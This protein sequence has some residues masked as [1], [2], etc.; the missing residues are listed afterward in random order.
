MCGGGQRGEE[1]AGGLSRL[2]GR[3]GHR[4]RDESLLE[5]A[6]THSSASHEAGGS[7]P[8]NEA[9]EL[10]GDAVLGL[11]VAHALLSLAPD[12]DEGALSRWRASLVRRRSLAALGRRLEVGRHLRL[13]QGEEQG[14]GRERDS[15]LADATEALVAALYLDGG[16]EVAR[17]FVQRE[18]GAELMALAGGGAE[19]GRDPKS[20]L[21]ERL[22]AGGGPPPE[23]R[24]LAADG[25]AHAPRF[26]VQVVHEGRI[27]AEAEG[28]SKQ[29]AELEAARRALQGLDEGGQPRGA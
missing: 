20:A 6:L 8:S 17:R 28:G 10:L 26:R 23:Y 24:L 11:L 1:R 19:A 3:L 13:G 25:P 29:A 27:L 9:L 18:M 5:R 2:E 4:F 7:L 14:G 21:Q 22:Q 16:L 12:S 15:L